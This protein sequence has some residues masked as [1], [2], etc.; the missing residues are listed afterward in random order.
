MG[1]KASGGISVLVVRLWMQSVNIGRTAGASRIALDIC[2]DMNNILKHC[3]LCLNGYMVKWDW[4][5]G[6]AH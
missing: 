3:N 2:A 6:L 4:E 1:S 5:A